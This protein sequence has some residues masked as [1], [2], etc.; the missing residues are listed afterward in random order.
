MK[1][2]ILLL[3]SFNVFAATLTGVPPSQRT[4][5]SAFNL[6]T[7]LQGFKVYCGLITKEYVN[8]YS[9][10]G[11]TLPITEW[12]L[13]LPV[14]VHYCAVTTIDTDGRE[15]AYSNEVTVTVSGKYLPKPPLITDTIIN[16]IITLPQP[17]N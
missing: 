6:D 1:Y 14:G 16:E 11:Y 8:S 9:Y 12:T 4:D 2:L 7:E 15:S 3:L 5:N 17:I 10:T 13:S